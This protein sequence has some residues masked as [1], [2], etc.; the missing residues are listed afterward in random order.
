MA[1]NISH[2][3]ILRDF[4]ELKND[5][6]LN[7]FS[8]HPLEDNLL[9]W[10]INFKPTSGIYQGI[11]FHLIMHFNQNPDEPLYPHSPPK[12]QLCNKLYHPNIFWNWFG[13]NRYP[14]I[15]LDLLKHRQ[16]YTPKYS[17]WS[18]AY[19]LGSILMQ[20]YSFFF[21]THIEQEGGNI[22][23]NKVS[24]Q[25]IEECKQDSLNFHCQKCNH[26]YHQPFPPICEIVET[27]ENTLE[28][29]TTSSNLANNPDVIRYILE[30]L[31]Y[32]SVKICKRVEKSWLA[33]LTEINH[34]RQI[35]CFHSKATLT[36]DLIGI[37]IN[38]TYH[39][40]NSLRSISSEFDYLSQGAFDNG[41]R[42]STW[43][44]PITHFLP[45]VINKGNIRGGLNTVIATIKNAT[46]ERFLTMDC[47]M[48]FFCTFMNNIVVELFQIGRNGQ[49]SR[50]TSEKAL[51]GYT[52]IHHLILYLLKIYP[53][54]QTIADKKVQL[55]LSSER[56]KKQI[57]DLGR[58]LVYL[59][60]SSPKYNWGLI[61][62]HYLKE[63]FVRNVRWMVRENR[64]LANL[65]LK[66]DDRLALTFSNRSFTTSRSL[67]MF[68]CYFLNYVA[69][70][71][72]KTIDAIL[73]DYNNN[74]GRP[75]EKAMEELQR[76]S[77]EIQ[78]VNNW[79]E[80]FKLLDVNIPP[81]DKFFDI[82]V[83]SI[84]KSK[85]MKYH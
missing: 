17:G 51:I 56:T 62:Y 31:P 22:V 37:G 59:T 5:P 14:Y 57:P 79:M 11:I 26:T 78:A 63:T 38:V 48:D 18:T 27:S 82:W 20:L 41:V 3:R 55:F 43:N 83:D 10:H 30:F 52:C 49:I 33:A 72:G 53:K 71:N 45:L 85:Q 54:M 29:K 66:M 1:S 73:T 67:I 4:M 50:H 80:Y 32:S 42:H 2:K 58:F 44:K 81:K 28:E 68:Q 64:Q 12:I 7:Y 23:E 36:E 24:V 47:I 34:R 76:R 13:G 74:F 70:P 61:R 46:K 84:K 15:C 65:K 77:K 75:T 39:R 40:D 6:T 19:T 35:V 21:E 9:E 69:R 60:I 16:E 8:I 25:Q